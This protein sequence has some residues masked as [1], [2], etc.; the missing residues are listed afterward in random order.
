[1]IPVARYTALLALF[2]GAVSAQNTAVPP[3]QQ[4]PETALAVKRFEFNNL[5]SLLV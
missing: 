1:M 3:E 5:V 2:V 4:F